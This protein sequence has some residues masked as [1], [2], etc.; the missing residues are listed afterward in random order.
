MY[1]SADVSNSGA[2]DARE[3]ALRLR[4]RRLVARR[5]RVRICLC[6]L[7]FVLSSCVD[8]FSY[9]MLSGYPPFYGKTENEKVEKILSAKYDFGHAVWNDVSVERF[10]I[11]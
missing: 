6:V 8:A 11:G 7:R 2:G 5:A 9:I 3:S 4:R 10:G 1:V